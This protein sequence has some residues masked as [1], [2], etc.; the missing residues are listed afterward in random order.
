MYHCIKQ[1]HSP[2]NTLRVLKAIYCSKVDNSTIA[3]PPGVLVFWTTWNYFCWGFKETNGTVSIFKKK[4]EKKT[5]QAIF[6]HYPP[7]PP[8]HPSSKTWNYQGGVLPVFDP[9]V[10]VFNHTKQV[11]TN[12]K[13]KEWQTDMMM[14]FSES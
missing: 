2:S 4:K 8:T 3:C 13:L 5:C 7:P 1:K 10:L 11:S 12:S 14:V 9:D 6:S